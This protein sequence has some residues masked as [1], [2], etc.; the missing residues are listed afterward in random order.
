MWSPE[1]QLAPPVPAPAPLRPVTRLLRSAWLH[2]VLGVVL[3]RCAAAPP[4]PED[5]AALAAVNLLALALAEA[6]GQ[7]QHD[8]PKAIF[9]E[10][11]L[12]VL[13]G[14]DVLGSLRVLAGVQPGEG[15]RLRE[16]G[17]ELAACARHASALVEAASQ[18]SQQPL[19]Q[20]PEALPAGN[21]AAAAVSGHEA[22]MQRRRRLARRRQQESLVRL[23]AQQAR[24]HDAQQAPTSEE[25]YPGQSAGGESEGSKGR[26]A[27]AE[28]ETVAA[29][30][31]PP[32]SAAPSAPLGSAEPGGPACEPLPAHHP[33]AWGVASGMCSLCHAGVEAGPL[34]WVTQV[35]VSCLP[36]QA[37]R[38]R[39]ELPRAPGVPPKTLHPICFPIFGASAGRGPGVSAFDCQA[40]VAA[41]CCGHVLHAGCG[42]AYYRSVRQRHQEGQLHEGLMVVEPRGE[43][44]GEFLCPIC[45]RL[46]N[47]LLPV[48]AAFSENAAPFLAHPQQQ[49]LQ[50]SVPA[51]GE[52]PPDLL[53]CVERLGKAVADGWVWEC[54]A[55]EAFAWVTEWGEED[56]GQLGAPSP[57]QSPERAFYSPRLGNMAFAAL[58]LGL[59]A[60]EVRD[61]M[62]WLRDTAEHAAH[63]EL[64]GE[65]EVAFLWGTYASGPA[66]HAPRP[67][68][69][70]MSLGPRA[71][72][73]QA[74]AFDAGSGAA[75]DAAA[76]AAEAAAGHTAELLAFEPEAVGAWRRSRLDH[77]LVHG[78]SL[79]SAECAQ[80]ATLWALLGFNVA[81]WEVAHRDPT[82]APEEAVDLAHWRALCSI[83]HAAL[84]T[85]CDSGSGPRTRALAAEAATAAGLCRSPAAAAAQAA[86]CWLLGARCAPCGRHRGALLPLPDVLRAL[87]PV[88]GQVV[89]AAADERGKRSDTVGPQG[90][91]C[92]PLISCSLGFS[93]TTLPELAADPFRLA[94]ELL[95]LLASPTTCLGRDGV[96]AFGVQRDPGALLLLLLPFVHGVAV[97]Q[98]AALT[99]WP[100]GTAEGPALQELR[101]REP[102]V[103]PSTGARFVAA[104]LDVAV[105]TGAK[106][107]LQLVLSCALLPLLRRCR[108]LLAL[109]RSDEA[110]PVPPLA[111]DSQG[112]AAEAAA[113]AGELGL[114]CA[115]GALLSVLQLERPL[116]VLRRW[117]PWG[118]P[119]R[120]S[121][122]EGE[123]VDLSSAALERL[124]P[125]AAPHPPE[126]I[127]LP[128]QYQDLFLLLRGRACRA[129]GEPPVTD[130]ALCLYCGEV[131]CWN[132]DS[133]TGPVDESAC[134]THAAACGSGTSA[135]L[136][137]RSTATL[138]VRKGRCTVAP[139]LYLD[140]HGEEDKQLL[141][142]KP[143]QLSNVRAAYLL[144]LWRGGAF[145]FDTRAL[146]DAFLGLRPFLLDM[147]LV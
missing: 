131:V 112:A 130:P 119:D 138:L 121:K 20:P 69:T 64:P 108:L 28:G 89:D 139:S 78:R 76:A 117:L 74:G 3:E 88:A 68:P 39:V 120:S 122:Q 101:Q 67:G 17:W 95:A 45:R 79:G 12:R 37:R 23:R 127:H 49:Q 85:G 146:H 71:A 94:L 59:A 116:T 60:L 55:P 97:A 61:V 80:A 84:A 118:R 144:R 107:S 65:G 81:Q 53:D 30:Q 26:P 48:T 143:L 43:G 92:C 114:P 51:E 35:S 7:Q 22:D 135:F 86:L 91:D 109:L 44:L 62:P 4:G 25:Q 83:C 36:L 38:A 57:L 129:C 70:P 41:L 110:P 8:D 82:G 102:D 14:G 40:G 32:T 54:A 103:E 126:L 46:G 27:S 21:E 104:V 133:C 100:G 140:A 15:G 111:V 142:G 18:P 10:D 16:S 105:A 56:G 31:A 33:L 1:Q 24:F 124:I 58:K 115:L 128:Q 134:F 87:L 13:A 132:N 2:S 75:V 136:L 19:Q 6:S 98:A 99:N 93:L 145:D 137:V 5:A 47:A 90:V 63:V 147:I 73:L 125:P 72:R 34:C 42:L 11:L 66:P 106:E 141:R 9:G 123:P 50:T 96:A 77:S 29:E 52:H 113:I